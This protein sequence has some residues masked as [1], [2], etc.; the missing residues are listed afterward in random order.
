MVTARV[1]KIII[2][3]DGY[4]VYEGK[5]FIDGLEATLP[6]HITL[7]KNDSTNQNHAKKGT[8]TFVEAWNE[9]FEKSISKDKLYSEVRQ[10]KIPH[11][12]IGSK[13]LFNRNT[14]ETWIKESEK[15]GRS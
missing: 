5:S 3:I 12:K 13:I 14:L 4:I 8:L 11:F 10:G 9:V 2:E 7:P 15:K 6:N 1:L